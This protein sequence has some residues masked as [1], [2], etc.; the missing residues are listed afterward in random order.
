M[1]IGQP[2]TQLC[3]QLARPKHFGRVD[4][5]LHTTAS[6]GSYTPEQVIDL[7]RRS[8][9]AAVAITDHDTTD[10]VLAARRAGTGTAVE[11]CA[12]VEIT[13]EYRGKE[14]H[15]LGYCFSLNDE[16]LA[17]ALAKL[18][19]GRVERFRE[20]VARLRGLGVQV[21][22]AA[23]RSDRSA[24]GR[25]HLAELVVRA[26]KAATVR[27]AFQRYLGDRG[28]ATVPKQRLPVGEAISL[29]RGAGGVAAW[30][31]PSYDCSTESLRELRGLG[32]QAIE[33]SFPSCRPARE[34]ELRALASRRE[35]LITGG[36]DCHGP[37]QPRQAIGACSITHPEFL[38][39]KQLARG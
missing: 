15:L 33:A 30:A 19:S 39:V 2:F 13:A 35:L 26:G 4:L 21:E 34:R 24:L 29:V 7:A 6:D 1:P 17:R 14:L 12:G 9:L 23:P 31:H 27:E 5:H 36:S 20:M 37:D 10:A 25:R 28:R 11:V 18:R 3:Q 22:D 16:P 38:A 32:L 8:G